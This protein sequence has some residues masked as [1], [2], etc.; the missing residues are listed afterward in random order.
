MR[1]VSLGAYLTA[2]LCRIETADLS[3]HSMVVRGALQA[4]G[5]ILR[6]DRHEKNSNETPDY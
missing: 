2:I 5:S 4:N 1:I 3:A 6:Y